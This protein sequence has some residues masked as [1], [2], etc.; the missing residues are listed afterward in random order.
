MDRVRYRRLAWIFVGFLIVL[1]A[2][3]W[4][5]N[6]I[7]IRQH[8]VYALAKLS[9]NTVEVSMEPVPRGLI[10]DR[11]LVDLTGKRIAP[12]IVVIPQLIEE[13]EKIAAG[14]SEIMGVE[15]DEIHGYLKNPGILPYAVSQAQKMSILTRGWTGVGVLPV[16][17][18]YGER[19]LAT[20]TVGHLGPCTGADNEPVSRDGSCCEPGELV[21]KSGVERLY[22]TA[23]RGS[24]PGAVVRVFLD[25]R[26]RSLPGLG[27]VV[28]AG[29]VDDGRHDVR[30]TLDLRIQQI[31]EEVADEEIESGAV[32]VM[33]VASGDILALASRPDYHPERVGEYLASG[34]ADVFNNQALALFQP[35]SIFKIVVAA[36]ALEEGLVTPETT[37]DCTGHGD[38][39]IKCWLP[40]GH[41]QLSFAEAF[42]VSCNPVFARLALE[43]GGGKL[44]EY[45]K[46]FRLDNQDMIGYRTTPDG[47]QD[48]GLIERP[49]NLVNAGVGQGPVLLS[50]VQ[51]TALV[52]SIGRDGIYINPRLVSETRHRNQAVETFPAGTPE[53]IMTA[54]T[55]RT[56][57]ELLGLVTIDG[58]GAKA[59][60]PEWG[61]A[62]KTGTAQVGGGTNNAWFSGYF[63]VTDPRYAVTVLVRGAGS[64]GETAAPIFR[65]IAE[66]TII[67]LP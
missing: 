4:R 18:R 35:G 31:V 60:V 33:D 39:L 48:F 23:L 61:S 65:L 46:R 67:E 11:N 19:P 27:L 2:L 37:F 38:E 36:A 3:T 52:A 55:A 64:G 16:T 15:D 59:F 20:H 13:P 63:P 10:L 12:R 50:P 41:G 49:F 29:A 17:F 25:A 40:E 53:R 6:E 32:V 45:A 51:I 26:G 57:A 1:A 22:Q 24:S 42:A 30:M 58:Q 62:G 54:Q 14:L 44:A 5:L 43:L 21:G 28:E 34:T 47:R 8:A 7:Q 56:L 9:Q 66:R